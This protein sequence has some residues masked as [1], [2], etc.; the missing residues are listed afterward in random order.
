VPQSGAP[1]GVVDTLDFPLYP[2]DGRVASGGRDFGV[3]RSRYNGNHTGEDWWGASRSQTFGLPVHSIGHG[4]VTYAAPLGWGV[5]QGVLIVRHTFP[6]GSTLLSFYGHL[7]PPSVVLNPGDCVAR[8]DQVG[9]IGRPRTSPHLHFEIRTHTPTAPGPGYWSGDPTLA[10]WLPPSRTIQ[11][12]RIATA[13]GVQWTRPFTGEGARGLGL[14]APDT[15]VAVQDNHL[16]GIDVADGSL[17]WRQPLAASVVDVLLDAGRS[18]LYTIDYFGRVEA[19]RVPDPQDDGESA[20]PSLESTWK[21]QLDALGLATLMPLPGGGVVVS[22]RR[23]LF[24]VSAAGELLWEHDAAARV[25]DWALD[26]DLLIVTMTGRQGSL[27]TIDAAGPTAWPA[28]IGGQPIVAGGQILLYDAEGIYRLSPETLSVELL[29]ALPFGSLWLGD[30]AALPDGGVLLAHTD[31][32]DKRLIL[33]HADGSLRWER[34]ISG[35]IQ[36]Q[37][38]FLAL[39]D[40]VYLASQNGSGSFNE[41]SVFALDVHSPELT[42]IFNASSRNPQ[43]QDT[44]ALGL[45]DGRLLV[46]VGGNTI[47]ALDPHAALE[48]ILSR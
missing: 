48:T 17:R 4:V 36:G 41:V 8:G 10:G 20:S 40:G 42:Q 5:D 45:G 23:Q 12:Y 11:D 27:W 39:E 9:R 24:G 3:Y 25:F 19:W 15:F 22:S 16:I 33:L 26:D 31:R 47:V 38:R 6:D 32:S 46:N 30:I 34:S 13:P 1:C 21:M 37:Q 7:D 29:Y 14:L 35:V 28:Q 43:P 2:P 18:A 44:W